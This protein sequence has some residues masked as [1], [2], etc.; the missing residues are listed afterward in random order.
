MMS[1]YQNTNTPKHNIFITCDDPSVPCDETNLCYK[2]TKLL[3]DFASQNLD[4]ALHIHIKKRIPVAAG[5]GGG[6][7]DAAA[8]LKGLNELL[9]LNW[10]REKLAELGVKL[11]ADVPFFLYDGP[12]ICEGIG[13]KITTLSS[14]PN[15]WILLINPNFPVSTKWVYEEFDKL[16][17]LQLTEKALDVRGL[18]RNFKG[19]RELADVVHNDLELVTAAKYPE[20]EQIKKMLT[21]NGAVRSWMSGSGPTVVGMFGSES[22]CAEAAKVAKE[23]NAKWRVIETSNRL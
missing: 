9:D 4:T 22:V 15:M 6:S 1:A 7:S 19:L 17:G 13:D 3:V 8:V 12:V 10:P 21:E 23:K 18:G 11:G 14:L 16:A 2:A 5:L 20:I